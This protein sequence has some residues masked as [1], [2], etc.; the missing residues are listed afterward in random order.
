MSLAPESCQS[1]RRSTSAMNRNS[2]RW[3]AQTR[4]FTESMPKR[5]SWSVQSFGSGTPDLA[6]WGEKHQY[7]EQMF[8][9]QPIPQM[10]EMSVLCPY[11]HHMGRPSLP[12]RSFVDA[13]AVSAV[14]FLQP[15]TA[16]AS[17]RNPLARY[18][19]R[20]K[21]THQVA[22]ACFRRGRFSF[23]EQKGR[24]TCHAEGPEGSKGQGADRALQELTGRDVRPLPWPHGERCHRA[25]AVPPR[26]RR[27]IRRGEEHPDQ[28]RGEG[29]R[30]G[31]GSLAAGG[32]DRHRI[33]RGRRRVRS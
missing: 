3:L 33:H 27:H 8:D 5:S 30:P 24:A 32:A 17:A 4:P 26:P 19:P 9:C 20:W 28:D 16:G 13:G 14:T 22:S 29:C 25:P 10:K 12:P 1:S 21:S 2:S 23:P 11:Q 31:G 15:K 7:I 6:S 18:L